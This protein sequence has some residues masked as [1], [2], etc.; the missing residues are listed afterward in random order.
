MIM[1]TL[2]G[3]I[4]V[5]LILLWILFDKHYKFQGYIIVFIVSYWNIMTWNFFNSE[6]SINVFLSEGEAN[7]HIA[8]YCDRL[9]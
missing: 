9:K 1:C 7:R 8:A 6:N 3:L 4:Y 2:V 5:R